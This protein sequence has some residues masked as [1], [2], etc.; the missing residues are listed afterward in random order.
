MWLWWALLLPQLS[1]VVYVAVVVVT[2]N[3]VGAA[4]VVL[5]GSEF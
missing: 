3:A 4:A 5:V 1:F 2:D